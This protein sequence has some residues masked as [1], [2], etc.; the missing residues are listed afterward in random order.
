[1]GCL[2]SVLTCAQ[3]TR[4]STRR[5]V[6]D[7]PPGSQTASS[8][9]TVGEQSWRAETLLGHANPSR[10]GQRKRSRS[11]TYCISWRNFFDC[12]QL[13]ILQGVKSSHALRIN[14]RCP[15]RHK[16]G[17]RNVDNTAIRRAFSALRPCGSV[18]A[19]VHGYPRGVAPRRHPIALRDNPMAHTG[20]ETT[21]SPHHA[22]GCA[23]HPSTFFSPPDNG[24]STLDARCKP[25]I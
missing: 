4:Q 3:A 7:E 1:M 21:P 14:S 11:Y 19:D 23:A 9:T 8:R 12:K 2:L 5:R 24:F 16:E 10:D 22:T 6:T 20:G 13:W 25:L 18:P 15:W 17:A